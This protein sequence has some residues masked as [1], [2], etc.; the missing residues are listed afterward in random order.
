MLF[1]VAGLVSAVASFALLPLTTRVIGPEEYGLFGLAAA[2]AALGVSLGTLGS[3]YLVFN[4][5]P[6]L[7][8]RRAGELLSAMCISSTVLTGVGAL[9]LTFGW[10]VARHSFDTLDGLGRTSLGMVLAA[11]L[12]T[13]LWI[14]AIDIL[15]MQGRAA[16]YTFAV[17]GSTA[18]NVAGTLI[19][20]YELDL[21]VDALF[22]GN[23]AGASVAA[24]FGVIVIVPRLAQPRSWRKLLEPMDTARSFLA[25]QLSD[26]TYTVV[27]RGV[28]TSAAGVRE[29]GLYTHSQRYRDMTLLGVKSVAR[30]VW[31]NSLSEARTTTRSFVST[32]RVWTAVHAGVAVAGVGAALLARPAIDLLTHG[33][34]AAAAAWV[35]AW[36]VFILLQSM[37]KPG[38]A[39]LYAHA[40]ARVIARLNI[41]ANLAAVV[42]LLLSSWRF[43][44]A[45]ALVALLVQAAS[46]NL[47]TFRAARRLGPVVDIDRLARAGIFVV[48]VADVATRVLAPSTVER[49]LLVAPV[50]LAT[51]WWFR[52]PLV[53]LRRGGLLRGRQ[54]ATRPPNT[55]SEDACNS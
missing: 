38:T 54:G 17:V 16:L 24:V 11:M 44:A 15:T 41:F 39:V 25:A 43:G 20:L 5:L 3:G 49:V 29:L 30:A 36:F 35:P 12:L 13:P 32:E 47:F 6:T 53:A 9:A 8:G 40:E 10:W 1:S 21:T 50:T 37:Q 45:G 48:A 34:F 26:A 28:L 7:D 42:V 19:G 55:P 18:A 27:E 14:I 46:Y 52:H 33:K 2:F 51:C 23:V 31:P 4:R 22:L